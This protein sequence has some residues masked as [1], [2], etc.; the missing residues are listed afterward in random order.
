MPAIEAKAREYL[1]QGYQRLV[2]FEVAGGGFDWYGRP[3]ANRTLSAYG[4]M[5]FEDMA[6]VHSVD[7]G[8]IARTRRWLVEQQ[9]SDG[10]WEP[11]SHG[12]HEDPARRDGDH[13]QLATTAYIAW[14][15]FASQPDSRSAR[16]A[17]DYL[18]T[19]RADQIDDPY[20]LA[21]VANAVLAIDRRATSARPYLDRLEQLKH[22]SADGKLAS[23]DGGAE[24]RRTI[25]FGAGRSGQVET[26]ALA[27]LAM[28]G[29][30]GHSGTARAALAW[31]VNA[32]DPNGT[33]HSTQ[34][35][36]LALRALL[37]GTSRPLGEPVA[38]TISILLDDQPL[39]DVSIGADQADVM[40]QV[41]LSQHVTAGK[42]RL[43]LMD[44]SGQATGF[45]VASRY[46]VA[47]S[48]QP[49]K[50]ALEIDLVYDRAEL[51]I[52]D[53]LGATATIKNQT[54]LPAPMVIV[55]LPIPPGFAVDTEPL[56]E[57][58]AAEQIAK[59]QITPRSVIIYLRDLDP[60][61]PLV[62]S[63]KL[64]ATMSVRTTAPAARVYEYYD[65]DRQA[66]SG[67]TLLTVTAR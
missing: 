49:E 34:A 47:D 58:V 62:L 38:R 41:D 20:V 23:W 1:H 17:L 5:E 40:Q 65:P 3:P 64:K 18:R 53:T 51:K 28:L 31:L 24:D 45:E 42:H 14:A 8:L 50:Q 32:K 60:E 44:R 7:P 11:E 43:R 56:D 39:R 30:G 2:S 61:D 6:R 57:Y 4:L 46:H 67:T 55:D 12:L 25:F 59:Y 16:S 21:L 66:A 33:W 15:A 10:S 37:A 54:A 26:T 35:T 13:A 52:N 19:T 22:L 63:Y 29:A 48:S 27:A 9:R 36:V